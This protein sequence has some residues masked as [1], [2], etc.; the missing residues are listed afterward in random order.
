MRCVV[1]VSML[2]EGWDCNTVTHILGVRAFG[3]QLLCEQVV[4]RG[5][6]RR[7]YAVGDDGRFTPEYAEVYGVPFSFIPA[8]GATADPKPGPIPTRVRALDDRAAAEITFQRVAGYRWKIPAAHL[9]VDFDA[10]SR[11]ALDSRDVPTRT[12][13]AA[14]VGAPGEHRLER[15]EAMRTQEVAFLLAK[16]LLDRKFREPP[17]Q[18]GEP[19]GEQPWLFP[20]LL[21]ITKQWLSECVTLKDDA[22]VGLLAIQQRADD[23]VELIHQAIVRSEQGEKK[24]V[25]IMRDYDPVGSTADVDFD[26]TK[27]VWATSAERCHVSH[28]VCDSDW[29]RQLAST[30]E[31][32]PYVRSYVKNHGLGFTIPYTIDGQQR[33]YVPD[34]VVRLDDGR[35]DA[36]DPDDVLN[37]VVEVSGAGRRD[38][39]HKVRTTRELWVPAVNALGTYGRWAYVEVTDPWDAAN[40]IAAA[41]GRPPSVEVG[42]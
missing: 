22:F 30:L 1:S 38:K 18:E 31:Q 39:Q 20:R 9:L 29:E 32:L 24:L 11:L 25:A 8:S 37:L 14:I 4:G 5:L 10:G 19:E 21:A 13:V 41:A 36:D 6:R 23:A 42:R 7:S 33:S 15:F 16:R 28:V 35:G 40:V 34:F 2:T 12:E 17:P 26:T 3:T 27:P